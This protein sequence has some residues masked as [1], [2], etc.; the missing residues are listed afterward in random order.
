MKFLCL[1]FIYILSSSITY[2]FSSTSQTPLSP[3][4]VEKVSTS[5]HYD[6]TISIDVHSDNP[7]DYM[8]TKKDLIDLYIKPLR[9]KQSDTTPSS[10]VSPKATRPKASSVTNN[11]E[12]TM[13][14]Q[15]VIKSIS[16]SSNYKEIK[17]GN[18]EKYSQ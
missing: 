15:K 7:F 13:L 12:E 1:F 5:P 14:S 17:D 18:I 11:K 8:K 16:A 9:F 10:S 4:D 6:Q 2:Q 3:F